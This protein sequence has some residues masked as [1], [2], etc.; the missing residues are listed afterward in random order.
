MSS[1]ANSKCRRREF[2]SK[3]GNKSNWTRKWNRSELGVNHQWMRDW[4][5]L[6]L[7]LGSLEM[8]DQNPIQGAQGAKGT[9]GTQ[10]A[11]CD[12]GSSGSPGEP[13]QSDITLL[14][15]LELL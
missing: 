14:G 10:R 9:Q 15:V 1:E 7:L 4:V 11:Q 3:R 8:V 12:L 6:W 2:E 13:T 5:A